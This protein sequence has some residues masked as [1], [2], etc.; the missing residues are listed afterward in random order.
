MK[1]LGMILAL[2]LSTAGAAGGLAQ[3]DDA[4]KK[5]V[6]PAAL[7]FKM[8]NIEGA[9]VDLAKYYGNVVLVVNVASKCGLTPQYEGLQELH[10]KHSGQGLSILGIPC[11]QFGKQEPGT[12]KE[13]K[14]FCQTKYD[15][16]FDMFSK[17]DVNGDKRTGLYGYLTA[18]ETKPQGPGNISWNFEKFLIN[19]KGEVIARY[20]PKTAP[21]DA[22][23]VK[24][25]ETAL[26]EPR[27]ADA[28]K[29]DDSAAKGLPGNSTTAGKK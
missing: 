14:S 9:E 1:R 21:D 27:P 23:F 5:T 11:N 16:S 8:K 24:A 6:T 28:P 29:S 26:A 15:V 25:I 22:D 20:S 7:N 3:D 2:A 12:E 17:I 10:E 18:F 13:I 4:D 19:R